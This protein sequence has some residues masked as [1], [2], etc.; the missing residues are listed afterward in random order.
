[1]RLEMCHDVVD[2]LASWQLAELGREFTTRMK[3][4]ENQESGKARW[5]QPYWGAKENGA[6]AETGTRKREPVEMS[7]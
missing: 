4:R 1:M 7:R 3:S 5:I 6:D 2:E